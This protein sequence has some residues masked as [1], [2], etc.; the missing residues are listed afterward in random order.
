MH[1]YLLIHTINSPTSKRKLENYLPSLTNILSFEVENNC[2]TYEIQTNISK[3]EL[4]KSLS[5]FVKKLALNIDER[6][7]LYDTNILSSLLEKPSNSEKII[8][9]GDIEIENKI[10]EMI[11]VMFKYINFRQ[12]LEEVQKNYFDSLIQR[13]N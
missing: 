1:I 9:N 11:I 8:L 3:K 6:V 13:Q 4:I 10:E 12:V 5:F 2:C 7:V